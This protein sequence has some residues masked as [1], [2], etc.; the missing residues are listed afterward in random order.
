MVVSCVCDVIVFNYL[1][2]GDV[3]V[4]ID[5]DVGL[6]YGLVVNVVSIDLNDDVDVYKFMVSFFYV[7]VVVNNGFELVL[8]NMCVKLIFGGSYEKFK[9]IVILV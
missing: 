5:I 2:Y 8:V 1:I 7:E 4:V 9:I 3:V 6:V